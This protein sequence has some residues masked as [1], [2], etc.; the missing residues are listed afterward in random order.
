MITIILHIILPLFF[1]TT[2]TTVLFL[3]LNLGALEATALSAAVVSPILYYFYRRDR[4]Q[5]GIHP[6]ADRK[7][8]G[9]AVDILVFG[10]ALCVFGNYIIEALGLTELSA[11]YE[12]AAKALYAPPFPVQILASGI[13]IPA[14]EELIFRG[15]F[16]ASLRGR[17]S[18]L[19]A[20]V[21]SAL[22]F[23][24]YHG[25]LPQGVYAFL[26]G[27]AAAWLYEAG[28][29]MIAPYLFHASANIASLCIT[30]IALLGS[31]FDTE[32]KAV[33]SVMVAASAA[34]SVICAVRIYWKYNL[35]EDIV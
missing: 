5:L 11:A 12:E 3:C 35:K 14:A 30:N 6:A 22:L 18:F 8:R 33:T 29:T 2:I 10:A 15:M 9:C 21:L 32:N 17:L 28:K 31:L 26:I 24:L 4:K 19:P 27:M 20:A 25:N 1:Y 16:F 23:G 34:V 13:L 7:L